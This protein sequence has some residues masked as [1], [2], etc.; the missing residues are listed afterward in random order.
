MED[1]CIIDSARH[2]PEAV[3]FNRNTEALRPPCPSASN[4]SRTAASSTGFRRVP[5]NLDP[6]L[7]HDLPRVMARTGW[8]FRQDLLQRTCGG[9]RKVTAFIPGGELA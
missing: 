7:R 4:V 1:G 3:S 6:D 2:R 9:R 8:P 5:L